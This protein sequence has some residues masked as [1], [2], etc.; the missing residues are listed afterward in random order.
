MDE[1]TLVSKSG[2]IYKLIGPMSWQ[3]NQPSWFTDE[4]REGFPL[5]WR[6]NTLKYLVWLQEI[7]SGNEY[8]ENDQRLDTEGA[9]VNARD[10]FFVQ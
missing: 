9:I 8:E 7:P 3:A 5:S 2:T 6:K 1:C 10:A 4:F